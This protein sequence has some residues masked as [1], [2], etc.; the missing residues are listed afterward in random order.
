VKDVRAVETARAHRERLVHAGRDGPG[1]DG[2]GLST[3]IRAISARVPAATSAVRRSEIGR[4]RVRPAS[5]GAQ[6]QHDC[7]TLRGALSCSSHPG[8][9]DHRKSASGL[10]AEYIMP[11]GALPAL[12]LVGQ[13]R[14]FRR[15]VDCRARRSLRARQGEYSPSLPRSRHADAC[16]GRRGCSAHCGPH[17]ED[18]RQSG[19]LPRLGNARTPSPPSSATKSRAS[20]PATPPPRR[21]SPSR[22]PRRSPTAPARR[23]GRSKTS[24]RRPRR[25]GRRGARRQ[26]ACAAGHRR[27]RSPAIG[28]GVPLRDAPADCARPAHRAPGRND[29]GLSGAVQPAAASSTSPRTL[30][31]RERFR[32]SIG[33]HPLP[34]ARHCLTQPARGEP[35]VLFLVIPRH[36][37]HL[38]EIITVLATPS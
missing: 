31:I 11:G 33:F 34:G 6:R 9:K 24:N 28:A 19:P 3:G 27:T 35:W 22:R 20:P 29:R 13:N 36:A 5:D 14:S 18:P 8:G 2:R 10:A 7:E 38:S 15:T 16:R 25:S 4:F 23:L 17:R 37:T 32:A 30:T 26:R 21:A 12:V 1:I